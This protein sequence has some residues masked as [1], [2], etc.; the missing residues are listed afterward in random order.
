M[1]QALYAVD[2]QQPV[3]GVSVSGRCETWR[4]TVLAQRPTIHLPLAARRRREG[5][6]AIR[7]RC[8][9][10][11]R[12]SRGRAPTQTST[13]ADEETGLCSSLNSVRREP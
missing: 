1:L 10:E 13:D 11:R 4:V 9:I 3:T 2:Q 5:T 8:M 6:F 7:P 12:L